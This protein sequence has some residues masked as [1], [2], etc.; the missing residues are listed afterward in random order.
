MNIEPAIYFVSERERI[1]RR[2]E[3]GLPKP[4]TDDS[5]MQNERFCNVRREHD[6]VTKY[7]AEH[8]REPHADDPHLWVAMVV[9]RLINYPET[10]DELGYLQPWDRDHFKRV[11]TARMQR[12]EQVFGSAYVIPNGG[13]TKAKIGY[14]ADDTIQPMWE[15]RDLIIPKRGTVRTLATINSRLTKFNGIGGFLSGQIVADLK[16][17]EPLRSAPDW[18]TFAV[19]GPGSQRGLSRIMGRSVETSWTKAAWQSAFRRFEAAIRPE[20]ERIGM[21]DLHAQD[22]QNFLCE[23]DKY[24]RTKLGEGKPKRHYPGSA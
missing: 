8:W 2:R 24:L 12:G 5:I 23:T 10:L 7:I 18:M 16:Y 20:L 11:L 14:L 13:S 15:A 9:A 22:L 6:R 17:V 19:S 21:G 1:R 3:E 4:W